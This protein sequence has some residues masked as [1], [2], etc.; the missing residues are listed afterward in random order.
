MADCNS[1]CS[2]CS[3]TCSDRTAPSSFLIQPDESTK[4]KKIIGIVSG[5]GGVGKS[6]ITSLLASEMAKKGY[7]VGI[8][9]ADITG[10]SIPKYFG[11]H[12]KAYANNEGKIIPQ[13]AENG[14]KIISVNLILEN[15]EDPVIWRGPII[16]GVVKQFY[17]DVIWDELDYLFIDMPPGTGDVPLTIFQS[18]PIDG[19]VVATAPSDLISMI[20]KKAVKMAT[21]M[22]VDVIGAVENMSYLKCPDCG[23][24]IAVFG[25]SKI[26]E[27]AKNEK[28]DTFSRIPIDPEISKATDA[29]R[30]FDIKEDYLFDI[31]DKLEII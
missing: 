16:A 12:E 17:Q 15:E 31:V 21:M 13:V 23:K 24:E 19:I 2:D 29:G 14:V 9:D 25:E 6:L 7:K 27:I 5:K 1:N 11:I 20:V 10:P 26:E 30:I 22:N 3:Q 18:L 8:L 28:I 4:I